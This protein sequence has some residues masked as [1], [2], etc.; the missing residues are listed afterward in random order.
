MAYTRPAFTAAAAQA[1]ILVGSLGPAAWAQGGAVRRLMRVEIQGGSEDDKRFAEAALGLRSGAAVDDEQ[2]ALGL[3]AVRMTDRFLDLQ[4]RLEG[5]SAGVVAR[6]V[7]VPVP[8]L[9]G[10]SV[11]GA[12]P[13]AVKKDLFPGLRKGMHLGALRLEQF[14]QNA[15]SRLRESGYPKARV[16][17][18]RE[19]D[20]ARIRFDLQ[21]DVPDLVRVLRFEGNEGAYGA[22]KLL[23]LLKAEPGRTLWTQEFRREALARVRQ[24]FMKD[25]RFQGQAELVFGD[26]GGLVLKADPGPVVRLASEGKGLGFKSLK[27]L[28]PLARSERYSPELLE[29]GARSIVRHLRSKGYLDAEVSHRTEVMKGSAEHPEEIR[30]T[31]VLAPGDRLVASS[32]RFERNQEI[33]SAEL[34]KAAELP[35]SWQGLF[36]TRWTTELIGAVEERIKNH[37]RSRGYADISLRKLPLEQKDGKGTLVFQVREGSRRFLEAL[38]LEV[39]ADP[40]FKAWYLAECLTF[41]FADQPRLV[42]LDS[43]RVRRFRSERPG[44]KDIQ[45]ILQ[46]LESEVT[47]GTRKFRFS[48]NRP[49][50]LLKNDLAQVLSALRQ[51]VAALGALRP[52]QK[53]KLEAGAEGTLAFIEVPAQPLATVR[54]L[55]VQGSDATKARAVL[56]EAQLEPGVPMDPDRL[57]KAQAQVGNLGGFEQVDLLSLGDAGEET[58][59]FAWKEGDLLLKVSE[60]SPWVFSSGFGYDKSQ[61]YHFDLGAQRLN[62]GGM[63]R[64][65][66]FGVRAGDASIRNPTLRKWFPTGEFTRSVDMYRV[67]YTDPWFSP[68]LLG[69]WLPDRTQLVAEGAYIEEQRSAYLLRRRRAQAGLEWELKSG[70]MLQAGYRF[71]RSEVRALPD[72]GIRDEELAVT[73]RIPGRTIISAPYVQIVRDRRDNRLDPISG[74][75]SAARF[76]FANQA[77]G[78]SSNSSFVKLDFRQ[79]W[80][81]ALGYK[82]SHGVV[83]LGLRA[84]M[85]RP[86]ASSAEDLPLSERFF[87]GGPGTHRGVEPDM[88]G[89]IVDV[90]LRG[91]PPSYTQ[92][93]DEAGNP[94]FQSV[95]LGGQGLLLMN[96]EYRF[97]VY[98]QVFWGEVFV[99]SGQVYQS[100]RD[101]GQSPRFPP[102]RTALGVGV[103]FKI[104]LPIKLEY[105]ADLKRILGRPRTQLEQDTQLKSLLVSAGFQF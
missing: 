51:R 77:F 81:W 23:K 103:I 25:K 94:R 5:S 1:L 59:A 40:A 93:T 95:P 43:E 6:V 24:R 75:F 26:D 37:Y 90:P 11:G 16:S 22:G 18:R 101:I 66:D 38:V 39:P 85:A 99:D 64:T 54:R 27:D 8:G 74:S 7:V 34:E 87:A 105:A 73:A 42:A 3:T 13:V 89:T 104:G 86:T 31:Y 35:S 53:L 69:S 78:T 48:F 79:Q 96:L 97:P 98:G 28:V 55:V 70:F 82:A 67:G 29:A 30:V 4:G 15:E 52:Q 21:P 17:A 57:S 65:L 2:L 68:G 62:V 76:E 58:P 47:P 56:R 44:L 92:L 46:E 32:V 100:L 80:N 83:S 63:G 36:P 14:R 20:P 61:G 10:W 72:S 9:R 50:P 91:G 41:A 102:F 49:I 60:R 12:L 33:S 84:G 88:L 45:G 19:E 71:E